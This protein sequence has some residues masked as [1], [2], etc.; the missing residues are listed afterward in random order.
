[1]ANLKVSLENIIPLTEA[2]DHFSQIVAEVQR[3]KLYVLTKGGKP[4]VAIIDVKYLETI[5]GG[6]IN[7]SH[8]EREIQKDPLKVGRTPM[9]PHAQVNSSAPSVK[10]VQNNSFN[11]IE[12]K[13][14]FTPSSSPTPP[15]NNSEPKPN[16]VKISFQPANPVAKP[17]N[18]F[19]SPTPEP[20]P[21]VT[22]PNTPAETKPVETFTPPKPANNIPN[23]FSQPGSAS[24]FS[25]TPKPAIP[26]SSDSLASPATPTATSTPNPATQTFTPPTPAT[27]LTTPPSTLATPP[28]QPTP[29]APT[30]PPPTSAIPDSTPPGSGLVNS[31]T[32][33]KDNTG[34]TIDVIPSSEDS[35]PIKTSSSP[36]DNV[37]S[38]E[39]QPGA[40]QYA[41]SMDNSDPDDMAL[42]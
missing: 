42:D 3:D 36:F 14:D 17:A 41:G 2:R 20:K 23:T 33:P 19:D 40:A 31:Q 13:K 1:M 29:V 34:S 22:P 38:T 9:I 39:N 12:P 37:K 28:I 5:T 18:S 25:P 30:T 21:V 11:P 8:V 4:A 16:P 27:T 7:T 24:N 10:P 15:A 6:S 35:V 32:I 26:S